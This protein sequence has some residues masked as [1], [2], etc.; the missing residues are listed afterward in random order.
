MFK[1]T[2]QHAYVELD[3][4]ATPCTI[5][6]KQRFVVAASASSAGILVHMLLET[7]AA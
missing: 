4:P 6:V 5:I 1:Q 3:K 7:G 2:Q